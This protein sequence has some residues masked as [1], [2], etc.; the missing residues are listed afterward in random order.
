MTDQTGGMGTVLVVDDEQ[1]VLTFACEAL[2]R[3]GFSALSALDGKSAIELFRTKGDD[4]DAVLLDISMPHLS[5]PETARELRRLRGDVVIIFSS[6]FSQH[7]TEPL[8]DDG[9]IYFLEKP[10]MPNDLKAKLQEALGQS[11]R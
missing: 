5:G 3:I 10:Y 4:I 9:I 7:K 1:V 11:C 2:K 6:G 8:L